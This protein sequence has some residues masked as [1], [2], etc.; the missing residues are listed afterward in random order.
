MM[1]IL[2]ALCLASMKQFLQTVSWIPPC[3][4][5]KQILQKNTLVFLHLVRHERQ[6][7]KL[8]IAYRCIEELALFS[9][10]HPHICKHVLVRSVKRK[11]EIQ[12]RHFLF[13]LQFQSR[14]KGRP[15]ELSFSVPSMR[16]FACSKAR[17]DL[18]FQMDQSYLDHSLAA[19]G[20]EWSDFRACWHLPFWLIYVC[21]NL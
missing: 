13:F 1:K 3:I 15:E 20:W 7:I 18:K 4:F 17:A 9:I 2:E 5:S 19:R 21:E 6:S 16:S 14:E 11:G 8:P 10:I 12:Q